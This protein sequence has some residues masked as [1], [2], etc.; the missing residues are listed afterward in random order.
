MYARLLREAKEG[1]D[2]GLESLSIPEVRRFGVTALSNDGGETG[3]A[4]GFCAEDLCH[5]FD[6]DAA[7][8]PL[9]SIVVSVKP[10][11]Q[12]FI[13]SGGGL[14]LYIFLK[15]LPFLVSVELTITFQIKN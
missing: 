1:E 15:F 3:A 5:S 12:F 14:G 2:D 11:S 10:I 13:S 9:S 4:L 8:D 7:H 6:S